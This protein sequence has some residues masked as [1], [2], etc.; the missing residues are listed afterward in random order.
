MVV[1]V[2]PRT[3][4]GTVLRDPTTVRRSVP[5]LGGLVEVEDLIRPR[6]RE[7]PPGLAG[8]PTDDE[9]AT[10]TVNRPVC[11]QQ[12][13]HSSGVAKLQAGEVQHNA[14]PTIDVDGLDNLTK[15]RTA[16]EVQFA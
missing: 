15:P 6:D 8:H 16:E 12:G 1:P 4:G 11:P 10:L 7:D 3:R 5:S 2:P 9:L 14:A 13:S